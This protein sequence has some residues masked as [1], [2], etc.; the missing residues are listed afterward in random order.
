MTDPM[1]IGLSSKR[2][3][4]IVNNVEDIPSPSLLVYPDRVEVNIMRMK[5]ISGEVNLLRPHVK[6]HKMPEIIRFQMK[7][8]INKFKCATIAEAEMV[9]HTGAKDILLAI[10]PVGPNIERFFKLKQQFPATKFSCIVDSEEVVFKLS[11]AARAASLEAN[12][13]ID[14]NNGMNRTGISPG[15]GAARLFKLITD[16]PGLKAEGLHVYDGHIH[17]HNFSE[18]EKACNEAFKPV[19]ELADELRKTITRP[20]PIIAGGTPTFP[21]HATRRGVETSPGTVLLWDYG[22]S[23]TFTDLDFLHSAVLLT[24]IVSKPGK[25][26]ICLD[27]GHKAIG[28]EMPQPRVKFPDMDNY[29]I[30]GH[31]E[32]HMVIRSELAGNMKTGDVLYGIPY[33][34]CPTV[35]RYDM[36]TVVRHGMASD[37][38]KVEARRRKITI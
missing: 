14:I 25:D 10:Q 8:G 27:L 23:S 29:D 34:I 9:A 37:E 17:E 12:L 13:Y 31:N 30:I 28:S 18:R 22:Y 20:L 1:E 38:W 19:S 24:R 26:L 5:A 32:E 33:H 21:I 15:Q 16:Q 2:Q 7:H 11:E 36:V 3:W 4:Y 6:T 35:D